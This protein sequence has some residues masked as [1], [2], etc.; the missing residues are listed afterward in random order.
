[1][2]RVILFA[3][4]LSGCAMPAV[5]KQGYRDP[6]VPISSSGAFDPARFAGSWSV[7]A[8]FGE[9]AACGATAEEWVAA[10]EGFDVQ[11]SHCV[12]GAAMGFASQG[13]IVGP[14]RIEQA[15][16]GG[17]ET[18]WVLWVDADYRIAAVG[19]PSGRFGRIMSRG[20]NPRSDLLDGARQV[21][22][23]NGYDI[24]RLQLAR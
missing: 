4:A 16:P 3:L 11:G 14:G 9:E 19:T 21:L 13:R 15:M 8:A 17:G 22:A 18:L 6:A 10:A 7:V 23:F 20:P 24:S 5:Q 1:M 2:H 12:G